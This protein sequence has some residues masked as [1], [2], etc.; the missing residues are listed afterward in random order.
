MI[1]LNP[2]RCVVGRHEIFPLR[3]GWITKGYQAWSEN[4]NVFEDEEAKVRLEV[5]KNMVS[6]VTLRW[7]CSPCRN[8]KEAL[9]KWIPFMVRQAHHER[10][11]YV[12]VRPEPVEGLNQKFLKWI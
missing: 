8:F 6:A 9:N 2:D 12:T 3:F 4:L 11:Q 7:R 1:F 5:G 10:N